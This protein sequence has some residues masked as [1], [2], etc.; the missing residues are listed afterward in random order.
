MGMDWGDPRSHTIPIVLH[1]HRPRRR[2][3]SSAAGRPL[4]I[5]TQAEDHDRDV[6]AEEMKQRGGAGGAG[7][8][9]GNEAAAEDMAGRRR[10]QRSTHD[11]LP[12]SA[13]IRREVPLCG[14]S[15]NPAASRPSPCHDLI[16]DDEVETRTDQSVAHACADGK[17][18]GAR[19]HTRRPKEG[20]EEGR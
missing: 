19:G 6:A 12:H 11:C 10:G 17:R 2:P 4:S 7:G 14:R 8:A 5:L 1:P 9:G 16:A 20:N 15:N 13:Q 3:V 18:R